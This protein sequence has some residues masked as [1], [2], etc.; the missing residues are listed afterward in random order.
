[1]DNLNETS[2][3]CR[4]FHPRAVPGGCLKNIPNAT[5]SYCPE[6]LFLILRCLSF[7]HLFSAVLALPCR[8]V[9]WGSCQIKCNL[10]L[11]RSG[12]GPACACPRHCRSVDHT[13]RGSLR[14]GRAGCLWKGLARFLPQRFFSASSS[15]QLDTGKTFQAV[16]RF[17][18]D[19]ELT[20]FHNGG[21]LNYM[22]RKMAK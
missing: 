1:M 18:T 12:L 4:H 22:I 20:Y 5:T 8:S 11:S 7:P 6:R 15:S 2:A 10:L 9:D 19:V 17:D 16:M 14:A 3:D 21:I 13:W